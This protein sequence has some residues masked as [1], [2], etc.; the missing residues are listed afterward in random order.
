M[1]VTV[2]SR[3]IVVTGAGATS[4]FLGITINEEIEDGG[5]DALVNYIES[6][7]PE[8]IDESAQEESTLSTFE[9]LRNKI[10]KERFPN[11]P[12]EEK[13]IYSKVLDLAM[14][15]IFAKLAKLP[16]SFADHVSASLDDPT[17]KGKP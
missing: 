10:L 16:T 11:L 15:S 2:C 4:F 8:E 13:V 14:G 7:N 6:Y 3:S 5:I 17:K 1:K 9:L 12:E